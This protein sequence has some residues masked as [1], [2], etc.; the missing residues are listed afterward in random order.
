MSTIDK[1]GLVC[2]RDGRMLLC[3]K[4]RGTQLLILPGGKREPGETSLETLQREVEEELGAVE[5]AAIEYL[6][7]Y[8]GPAAGEPG[9]T[10]YLELFRAGLI[11][12]PQ[13]QSEIGELVWFDPNSDWNQVSPSL[14]GQVLP[15]LIRRG[16]LKP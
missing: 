4:R 7:K 8:S 9:A 2:I 15:D 16:I 3:R 11:G 6:G 10:L 1:V 12:E 5:L 13:P 14:S